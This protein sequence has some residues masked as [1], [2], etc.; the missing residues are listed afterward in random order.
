V[1]AIRAI[2]QY[3]RRDVLAYLGLRYYLESSAARSDRWAEEVA[4]D[5]VLRRADTPYLAVRHFKE[6]D[7]HGLISHRELFL[8]GPNEALA[9][10]ALL[11]ACGKAGGAFL[12]ADSVFSYRLATSEDVSGVFRHYMHGLRQRHAAV[13]AACKSA[14]DATVLYLDIRRFYPSVKIPR[15]QDAWI[16]ASESSGLDTQ[17]IDLGAHLL[18]DHGRAS[19]ARDGHIL[20]GPMFSHLI[21]NVLLRHV[22]QHMVTLPARY[23]R[24]VDD[25]IL[26]GSQSEIAESRAALV[27]QLE[28]LDLDLHAQNSS[29][30]LTV[31]AKTWLQGENDYSEVKS[32]VSWMSMIGD[33]KRLL[34]TRP[35]LRGSLVNALADE[36]LRLPVPDY[37]AAIG[38][39]P[40]RTR[41]AELFRSNWFRRSVRTPSVQSVIGQAR[42]LREQYHQEAFALLDGISQAESFLAKRLLP[43]LR[44]RFGR[45]AYIGASS[46]LAG[47]AAA[48]AGMPALRFYSAVA[49][50]IATGDVSEVIEYGVNAAQAA[51]QP[52]R[53]RSTACQISDQSRLPGNEQ[54]LAVLKLNGLVLNFEDSNEPESELLTLAGK[55]VD[56]SLMRSSDPFV[57]EMACLHGISDKPR[58]V[59]ILDT[60]FDPAE[61]IALDAIEQDHGSS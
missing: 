52:L 45:L 40:Y 48:S 19:G 11:D 14:P 8:P 22:D 3:R 43:K 33:L 21:G 55:G 16:Q 12:P 17:W 10:A 15:A 49:S 54:S 13:A 4:T 38:E 29:K 23:F 37:S 42:M 36:D 28:E 7:S 2:N 50:S 58:H 57:R 9:E 30:S 46:Q 32:G 31:S 44:Y 1:L 61:E 56:R 26:V 53:M 60:A 24:Y 5:L 51:A 6:V 41:M 25:I 47:L 20:T 59:Q 35:E 39:R 34:V 27:A 18:Q